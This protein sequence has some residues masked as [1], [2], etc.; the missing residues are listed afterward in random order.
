MLWDYLMPVEHLLPREEAIHILQEA[1]HIGYELYDTAEC[2]T[3]IY[4][5]G[6]ISHNE[7]IVGEAVK[8]FRDEIVLCTKFGVNTQR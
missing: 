5:D 7:E 2:Y 1:H 6:S 3:G 4:P 8:N